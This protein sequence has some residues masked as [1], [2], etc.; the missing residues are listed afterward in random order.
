MLRAQASPLV[1]AAIT[2]DRELEQT[3]LTEEF[4]GE[5]LRSLKEIR[6]RL[7]RFGILTLFNCLSGQ[8]DRI[9][10]ILPQVSSYLNP[11]HQSDTRH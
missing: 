9:S 4:R 3:E 2:E 10:L 5:S 7:W 11:P 6:S 1:T 8:D